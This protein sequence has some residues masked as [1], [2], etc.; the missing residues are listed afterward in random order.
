M[1][2]VDPKD[3]TWHSQEIVKMAKQ[4]FKKTSTHFNHSF[5][6]QKQLEKIQERL[7]QPHLTETKQL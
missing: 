3:A 7:K 2:T 1:W 5:T 6:T 4:T